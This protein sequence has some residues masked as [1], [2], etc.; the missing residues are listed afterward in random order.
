MVQNNNPPWSGL[1][2]LDVE[3]VTFASGASL[4]CT[5]RFVPQ[6]PTLCQG[7][8]N[9]QLFNSA[10]IDTRVVDT[11]SPTQ[12]SVFASA[13]ADLPLCRS[14]IIKK[15]APAPQSFTPGQIIMYTVRVTNNNPNDPVTGVH[16]SDP[17]PTGFTYVSSSCTACSSAPTF[18][19]GIVQAS[20]PTINANGFVVLTITVKVPSTGGSYNNMA[21]ASFDHQG[22]FFERTG[23]TLSSPANIQVLTPK[24]TKAFSPPVGGPFGPSTLT[25]TLANVPG[26]PLEQG[27]TF[28]DTLTPGFHIVGPASTSCIV[29]SV[30]VAGNAITFQGEMQAGEATCTVSVAVSGAGC[31]DR[32]NISN[33]N[34]IDPSNANAMLNVTQCPTAGSFD[35]EIPTLSWWGLISLALLLTGVGLIRVWRE[36]RRT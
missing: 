36:Q 2:L 18:A 12:P 35:P 31:N 7:S 6:Q 5:I 25:F 23:S 17:L 13:T 28:T 10:F 19:G 29:G 26:N 32:T 15:T 27:I 8:G 33:T 3:P 9:P 24:L 22:N 11:N 14:I 1:S 16:V 30:T 21:F 4:T 34:N 20:I